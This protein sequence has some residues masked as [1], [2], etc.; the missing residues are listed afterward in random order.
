LLCLFAVTQSFLVDT[1]IF[2]LTFSTVQ[3]AIGGAAL[4]FV[5]ATFAAGAKSESQ[6]KED[7]RQ[8]KSYLTG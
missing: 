5:A 3:I 6:K 2:S 1:F 4:F 7:E 8:N